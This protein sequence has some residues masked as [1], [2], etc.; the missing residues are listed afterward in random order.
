M[1]A[2]S[3]RDRVT[4]REHAK[5]FACKAI[6]FQIAKLLMPAEQKAKAAAE[7]QEV[8]NLSDALALVAEWDGESR[9]PIT[10]DAMAVL[11]VM[12]SNPCQCGRVDCPSRSFV[13]NLLIPFLALHNTPEETRPESTD[14]AAVDGESRH[15]WTMASLAEFSAKFSVP[16]PVGGESVV[17]FFE[18]GGG[19]TLQLEWQTTCADTGEELLGKGRKWY[20]SKHAA[21][22]EVAQTLLAAS[23]AA[24][25]HEIREWFTFDGVPVY[26]PHQP[27]TE[28]AEFTAEHDPETRFEVGAA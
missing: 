28:L 19:F 9:V 26:R 16:S 3:E 1:V 27:L 14:A 8:K 7:I 22:N 18:A 25:E 5:Y 6:E 23:I 20:V 15:V 10:G 24:A 2:I 21:E 17:A 12:A 13:A 4:G 11:N